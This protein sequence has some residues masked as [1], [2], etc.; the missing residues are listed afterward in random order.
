MLP[1]GLPKEIDDQEIIVRFLTQKGHFNKITA[2]P[3]AFMPAPESNET[4]VSRHGPNP[5]DKLW[6]L[7]HSAA[8]E[9][10]LYGAAFV[11]AGKIR[12]NKLDVFSDEPPPLHSAIRNW[13]LV[14][15]DPELQ[16][17]KQKDLA[18]GLASASDPLIL[19]TP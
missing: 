18:N 16:K 15:K 9:R 5:S 4:S 17:A 3:A 8:G 12:E 10:T 6:E 14:E 2:K 11:T 13:P 1:S 19:F 7:G